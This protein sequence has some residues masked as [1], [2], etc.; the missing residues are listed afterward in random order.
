MMKLLLAPLF[1][2]LSVAAQAQEAPP[3]AGTAVSPAGDYVHSEREMIAGLRLNP[4]G[5]FEYALTVGS[6]DESAKGR[7]Q[8][9]GNR[10]RLT[11]DP[12]PVPPTITATRI[13]ADPGKPFS[14]RVL[15]PRGVDMPGVDMLVE[16]D[17]GDP[18]DTY[19]PGVPW[20][21]PADENRSP[22]FVTFSM[23]SYRLRSERLPL[24]PKP[25]T[26][27]IFSLTPND[28]GVADFTGA[29]VEF[30]AGKLILHRPEGSMDFR[31]V[32]PREKDGEPE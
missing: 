6:L 24:D 4:D 29:E 18:L 30:Q 5:S 12:R 32:E 23:P 25:G 20:T 2:L 13:D 28:F 15:T 10:I 9:E 1:A 16:F 11:S 17:S 3:G 14:I 31:R 21:V 19:T 7:W 26:T 27:A 22:R 8:A